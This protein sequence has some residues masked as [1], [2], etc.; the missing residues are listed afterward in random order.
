MR[1]WVLAATALALL[2]LLVPACGDETS[3][4]P[5]EQQNVDDA[6]PP[7]PTMT[8]P[9][10]DP[11]MESETVTIIRPL[12]ASYSP[13]SAAAKCTWKITG[14][15][16]YQEKHIPSG[17]WLPDCHGSWQTLFEGV[18]W[19]DQL[20]P[21]HGCFDACG[22]VSNYCPSAW[23]LKGD[24]LVD[25]RFLLVEDGVV[26][27]NP[28]LVEWTTPEE[29]VCRSSIPIY[30]CV[31]RVYV[32]L[33]Y[34][35]TP[36]K[37]QQ[38]PY[39]RRERFWECHPWPDGAM[40]KR[41]SGAGENWVS[42]EYTRGSEL[43]KTESF[44]WTLGASLG[45]EYE[46]LKAAI[47]GSITKTFSKTVAITESAAV[48]NDYHLVGQSGKLTC[49][50]LYVLVERY[51]FVHADGS[52]FSDPSYRITPA[53]SD[54]VR[55]TTYDFEIRGT[56]EHVAAYVFDSGGQLQEIRLASAD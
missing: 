1:T 14:R 42:Y 11:P 20:E 32:T 27:P 55:G 31:S 17:V 34:E 5:P 22:L 46:G 24:D 29:Y 16:R 41:Q 52:D 33:K 7:I 43:S 12:R 10:R 28:N 47:E 19:S 3:A 18:E 54:E 2:L 50:V 45:A 35:A 48:T 15:G 6:V 26:D 25:S 13:P 53:F 51:T 9:N 36:V 39:L 49:H 40:V 21:Y 4:P 30:G 38:M 44:A 37:L 23:A 8:D 56:Q